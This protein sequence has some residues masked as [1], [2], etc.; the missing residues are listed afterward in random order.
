MRNT[1]AQ[2]SLC[3]RT[4]SPE[5]MLFAHVSGRPTYRSYRNEV[6]KQI[7]R[8]QTTHCDKLSNKLKIITYIVKIDG[9]KTLKSF[10]KQ[11]TKTSIPPLSK[12]GVIFFNNKTKAD[13]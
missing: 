8:T 6:T 5:P 12:N 2:A 9:K 10:I 13:I 3:I 1:M 4:V 11:T 7:R